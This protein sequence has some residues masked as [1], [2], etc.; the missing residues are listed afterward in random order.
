VDILLLERLVP[1]ALAWLESRHSVE[2]RPELAA[3]P[4][5]LRKAIYKTQAL[6]VSR[7]VV[8]SRE[9]L[10][11]APLLRAVAR[12]HTSSDNTDLEACRDRKVR[13]IQASTAN[14]RSNAEYLLA[15]LLLLFR[16]GIGSSLIGDRHADIRVGRELS[17]SV[18]G[19]LGLAPT[20][21][22]LAPMLHALGVKLV[23]YDPAVHYTAPIW[24]RL[25]IQP[26]GLQELTSTSDAVSVQIMYASR[27][28][29]FVND[30]MLAYCKPGQVWVGISRS[31]LFDPDALARALTDGRIEAA[32]FDGAEAGFASKGSPLHELANLF[33][34][35]RLGAHTRE[36]RLR[37]SWYVAHR[38]HETLSM[39]RSATQDPLAS[40]SMELDAL[41]SGTPN[42]SDSQ[43]IIR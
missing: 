25:R 14:V 39:P 13:V 8:V 7:K 10:D 1:E 3:D 20:A 27:Y 21:H 18:V 2:C 34:T 17:G 26:V 6:V 38:I 42:F 36:A 15:A 16:R 30:K 12:M 40:G 9:F 37:A 41:P 28:H 22:T 35:P 32:M 19:I 43:F 11:F 29:G 4:V 23:G 24:S 33:L 5:A 31:H